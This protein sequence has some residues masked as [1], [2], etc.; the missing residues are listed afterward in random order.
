MFSRFGN[1]ELIYQQTNKGS[2]SNNHLLIGD[3]AVKPLNNTPVQKVMSAAGDTASKI[4]ES[5][6]DFITAPA[7]WLKD[8]QKNW[9]TYIVAV[10]VILLSI[11]ILYFGVCSYFHRKKGNWFNNNLVEL[12]KKLN[13]QAGIS[14]HP[15]PL[16]VSNLPSI[17]TKNLSE[18]IV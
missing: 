12:A 7:V 9:L 5:S 14:Q 1:S 2:A 4:I 3:S 6:G 10:A 13:N 18:S 15:L 11:V 16:T 17:L 8:I